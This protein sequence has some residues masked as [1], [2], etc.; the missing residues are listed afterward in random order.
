MTSDDLY[1]GMTALH[2]AAKRGNEEDDF[3]LTPLHWAA[4]GGHTGCVWLLLDKGA[5]IYARAKN[6]DTALHKAAWRGNKATVQH[7]LEWGADVTVKNDESKIP[8]DL[9]RE[10]E[11]A[12]MLQPEMPDDGDSDDDAE[13]SD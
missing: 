3:G 8:M 7:L 13:L 2:H 6:G 4:Y 5:D 11:I 9:A 10:T 12:A 1:A